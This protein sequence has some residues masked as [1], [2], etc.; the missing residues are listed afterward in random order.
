MFIPRLN[1]SATLRSNSELNHQIE[2]I[3]NLPVIDYEIAVKASK[4][5]PWYGNSSSCGRQLTQ[6]CLVSST[7]CPPR[8]NHIS[9][10]NLLV[11]AVVQ[12]WERGAERS[13]QIG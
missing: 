12:V 1:R 9:L 8:N 7:G 10:N 11:K 13:C 3:V 2:L 5:D 4:V 6:R